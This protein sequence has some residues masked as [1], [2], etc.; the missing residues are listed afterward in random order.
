M[1]SI[2][3]D[4]RVFAFAGVLTGLVS[5]LSGLLPAWRCS[6]LEPQQALRSGGRTVNETRSM[7]QWRFV[8]VGA[9][10]ALSAACL[11]MAGLLLQSFSRVLRVDPGFSAEN[12]LTA[13][14]TLMGSRYSSHER[15]AAFLREALRR[16]GAVPGVVA[17]GVANLMPLSADQNNNLLRP[18]GSDGSANCPSLNNASSTWAIFAH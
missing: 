15:R 14:M 2:R 13:K 12:V 4:G 9:E 8:L 10:V 7:T 3:L 1:E 16:T 11:V 18:Q 6:G 17:N 5:I